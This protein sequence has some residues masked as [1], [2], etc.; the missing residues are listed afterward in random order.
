MLIGCNRSDEV[1]AIFHRQPDSFL[2]AGVASRQ[3]HTAPM[4]Y[5]Y[6]PSH[7]RLIL[8]AVA[9][10]IATTAAI[11]PIQPSPTSAD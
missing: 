3:L 10:N 2:I 4:S 9:D 11:H 6:I 7:T 5:H 1:E 8:G